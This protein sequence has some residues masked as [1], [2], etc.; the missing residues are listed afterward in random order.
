MIVGPMSNQ[1]V[2]PALLPSLC[3][4]FL[5]LMNR[6]PAFFS[7]FTDQVIRCW[8]VFLVN[9]RICGTGLR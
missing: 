8:V 2:S 3:F 9:S 5:A 7:I 1:S 4:D 6:F